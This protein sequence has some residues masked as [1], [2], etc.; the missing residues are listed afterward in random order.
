M[1]IRDERECF[2][3]RV[4]DWGKSNHKVLNIIVTFSPMKSGVVSAVEITLMTPD[5]T[6]IRIIPGINDLKLSM[7]VERARG[8]LKEELEEVINLMNELRRLY[9]QC[10]REVG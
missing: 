1:T 7:V 10:L 8:Y 3:T 6:S 4:L 2:V 9:T 5:S